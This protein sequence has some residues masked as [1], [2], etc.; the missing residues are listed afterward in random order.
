M[1]VNTKVFAEFD[2]LRNSGSFEGQSITYYRSCSMCGLAV[3]AV[4]QLEGRGQVVY[5]I[6]GLFG[7]IPVLEGMWM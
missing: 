1:W 7:H 6:Q 3:A 2:V 4:P 5:F